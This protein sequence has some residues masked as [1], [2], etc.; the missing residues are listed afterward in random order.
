MIQILIVTHGPLAEA[1]KVSAGMFFP[2]AEKIATLSLNP[3][4]NPMELK[5]RIVA[6]VREIEE[7][8]GV[9][10]FVDL[11]AGTPCNMTALALAELSDIPI[12]VSYTHLDV[13]KSQDIRRI[14]ELIDEIKKRKMKDFIRE[15][16]LY[17]F[18]PDLF[19]SC[20][21]FAT[22]TDAVEVMCAAMTAGGY[23]DEDYRQPVSYT[24]LSRPSSAF[25][26]QYGSAI[27]LRPHIT[28]SPIPSAIT[29]SASCGLITAPTRQIRSEV[30]CLIRQANS[31][32]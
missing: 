22:H 31:A 18:H 12:P 5:D 21:Q 15:K 16:I 3:Q 26:G 20:R 7:G 28:A 17:F 11:F 10:M 1:L 23:V 29:A 14:F 4:D 25:F 19:F 27:R 32:L 2:Q 9:L 6:K 13:Y 24:H 8:E 30:S